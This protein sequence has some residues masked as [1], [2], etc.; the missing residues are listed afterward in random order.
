MNNRC[1]ALSKNNRCRILTVYECT[2]T[3]CPFYKTP[4]QATE[5]R[6]KVNAR[7]AGLDKAY[8]EHIADTYYRGKMPWLKEGDACED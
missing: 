3:D 8:Q 4:E 7:L 1:F 2:G 6:R 5:S